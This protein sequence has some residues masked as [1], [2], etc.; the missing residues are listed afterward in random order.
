MNWVNFL[1]GRKKDIKY[2]ELCVIEDDSRLD[3]KK[4]QFNIKN[5]FELII[6]FSGITI[7]DVLDKQLLNFACHCDLRWE[8]LIIHH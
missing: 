6:F 5:K 1:A 7:S 2:V 3:R 4:E 8:F